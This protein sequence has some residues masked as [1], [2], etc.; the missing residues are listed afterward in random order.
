MR[1]LRTGKSTSLARGE[2]GAAHVFLHMPSL[3]ITFC[4]Q[5]L[6]RRLLLLLLVFGNVFGNVFVFSRVTR[7][8]IAVALDCCMHRPMHRPS[9]I[10]V[11]HGTKQCDKH[12]RHMN[13]TLTDL[14]R[15]PIEPINHARKLVGI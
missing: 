10:R 7:R 2:D 11:P 9:C 1:D 14:E 4:L 8:W 15:P 5:G 6:R 12:G 3:L 13:R